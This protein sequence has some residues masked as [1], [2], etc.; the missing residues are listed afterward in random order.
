[1]PQAVPRGHGYLVPAT[2]V[3]RASDRGKRF[4]TNYLISIRDTSGPCG[5][6][7]GYSPSQLRTAYEIPANSGSGAIAIVDAYDYPTSLADFN[8][9][10]AQFGL[11]TEPSTNPTGANNDVFEVVYASGAK[12]APD[13]GWSQEMALDTQWAH[14]M[15]PRAKIYLVEA[16]SHA[17]T[18]L[19]AAVN[20]AKLLPGVREVSMS[21]G[22]AEYATVYTTYDSYFVQSGVTFFAAAGDI[23]NQVDFPAASQNVVSVGGTSLNINASGVWLSETAWSDTSCGPSLYEPRPTFQ[24]AVANLVGNFR[25]VADIAADADPNTGVSVFDSYGFPN[26][27][28][29]WQVFGGTSAATPIMA[30]IA[31]ASGSTPASSQ[32]E[33]TKLYA[34][35]G[36]AHFHDISSGAAGHY[37]AGAGWDFPTGV[38]TPEGVGGF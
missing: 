6:P 36:S 20:V 30:G 3:E 1:M 11:P 12:P 16:A 18:D 24:N 9:F 22:G 38:G 4:H 23:A 19:M 27:P 29:G 26:N 35:I 25:G 13:G 7:D 15:A 14:A 34:E 8:A 33:D 28:G 21:S 5:T 10:S 31:N 37:A 17:T 32:A 2:T